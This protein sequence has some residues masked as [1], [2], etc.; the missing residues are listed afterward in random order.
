[1]CAGPRGGMECAEKCLVPEWSPESLLQR[2]DVARQVLTRARK[3]VCPSEYVVHC[4]K[5]EYPDLPMQVIAHGIDLLSFGRP[6]QRSES[7]V[8]FGYLGSIGAIK[9]VDLLVRAF[10][11]ISAD[12]ARLVL[13]GSFES[14]EY[15]KRIVDLVAKD[16]RITLNPAVNP[17]EVPALLAQFD[18]LC[19]PSVVPETFSLVLHEAAA[20]GTP[21]LVSSLGAP[22]HYVEQHQCG[23][24]VNAGS[25]QDWTEAIEEVCKTPECIAG[26]Q[27]HLPLPMRV[28]EE[29][30]FY[31]SVY[32]QAIRE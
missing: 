2:A 13:V 22:R 23:R 15:G 29:A 31:Q 26:W 1:M 3:V 17:T 14:E 30:F 12:N 4:L 21:A 32:R 24:V 20:A 27:Q 7:M 9:G 28:E 18:V 16:A 5:Q 8:T 25:L 19:I 11:S 10:S 6:N